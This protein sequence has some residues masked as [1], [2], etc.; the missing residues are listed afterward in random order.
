MIPV[1]D[2]IAEACAVARLV[3]LADPRERLERLRPNI[4]RYAEITVAPG[5][6]EIVVGGSP[7]DLARIAQEFG[8]G[9]EA[10]GAFLDC[11][12][13]FDPA[14]VGLKVPLGPGDPSLYARLL[15]GVEPGLA[16]LGRYIP[17]RDLAEA[18]GQRKILYGLGFRGD[19]VVVKTYALQGRG[20]VSWRADASGIRAE[21]KDYLADQP[22]GGD[23]RDIGGWGAV[24]A[25][26]RA[27]GLDVAGHTSVRVVDGRVVQPKLYFERIGA[28]ETDWTAR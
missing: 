5:S 22:I 23:I 12:R 6:V 13:T 20:F 7:E 27:M 19:P 1:E 10:A 18:F 3:G 2:V 14:I 4:A 8:S 9:P 11:A 15:I 16:F 25:G 28:I 24:L 17:T 21:S 26:L